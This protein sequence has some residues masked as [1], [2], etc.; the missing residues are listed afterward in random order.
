MRANFSSS[1]AIRIF[2]I[3]FVE[4]RRMAQAGATPL[5]AGQARGAN[6]SCLSVRPR[7]LAT[8]IFTDDSRRTAVSAQQTKATS[9]RRRHPKRRSGADQREALDDDGRMWPAWARHPSACVK[10]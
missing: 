2:L 9:D 10:Q 3:W 1:R 7:R 6:A 4:S 8:L 5:I